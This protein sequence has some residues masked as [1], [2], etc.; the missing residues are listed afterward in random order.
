MLGYTARRN[1]FGKLT[2]DDSSTNLTLGDELMNESDKRI[3]GLRNWPFAK[4]TMN[5]TTTTN[6][7]T[8]TLPHKFKK[9]NSIFL[10][11]GS[12]RYQIKEITSRDEWV[13]IT[14]TPGDSAT[15]P[16]YFYVRGT[17]IEF[18]PIISTASNTLTV[19]YIARHKDLSVADYTTGT[20]SAIANAA[21]TVTG[22]GTTWTTQMAGRFIRITDGNSTTTSGDGEWYEIASVTNS[23][24]LVLNT[25]YQ[26]TTISGGT[27]TYTI[28]Q[29]SLLP[30]EYQVISL[31]EALEE[32]FMSSQDPK[33]EQA[34]RY[35]RMKDE[36]IAELIEVFGNATTSVV[37]EDDDVIDKNPNLFV[38]AS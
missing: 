22:S 30:E 29:V 9:I 28:A 2:G 32:Y 33:M 27:A 36:K 7:S 5:F 26:G 4:K 24:T 13:R 18:Y 6:Q 17:T 19:E 15:Y 11:S 37:V 10:L 3:L 34:D 16:D 23:T 12:T 20:I 21:T 25:A 8:L 14:S 35:K 1:R 38:T 31:Y